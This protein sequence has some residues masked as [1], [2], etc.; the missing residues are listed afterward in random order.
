MFVCISIY[1]IG[2][3]WRQYG[4]LTWNSPAETVRNGLPSFGLGDELVHSKKNNLWLHPPGCSRRGQPF[5]CSVVCEM[6]PYH[7]VALATCIKLHQPWRLIWDDMGVFKKMANLNF[8]WS[9][10]WTVH[11]SVGAMFGGSFLGVTITGVSSVP[12][13]CYVLVALSRNCE[14]NT[15]PETNSPPLKMDGWNT[16]SFP[17]GARPIFRG[18]LAVS[19]REGNIRQLKTFTNNRQRQ[20][21]PDMTFHYSTLIGS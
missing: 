12:N 16:F 7:T 13:P 1:I 21:N 4:N 3:P 20:Q 8:K 10:T 2:W 17:F 19:F 6:A 18:K 11:C 15:L 14:P 9:S 5:P